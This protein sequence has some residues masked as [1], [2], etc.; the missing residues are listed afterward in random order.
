MQ[1]QLVGPVSQIAN[2][3]SPTNWR[4]SLT[5]LALDDHFD[6]Q[7]HGEMGTEGKP[8]PSSFKSARA[9]TIRS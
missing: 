9:A 8:G 2:A 4:L 3:G 6:R 7:W 1:R 5:A